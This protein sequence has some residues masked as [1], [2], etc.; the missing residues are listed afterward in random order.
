METKETPHAKHRERMINKFLLNP[1]S[2]AEHELL[3][4]LLYAVIKRQDTNAL[5]HRILSYFNN[6]K[7]V[8]DADIETLQKIKGVG[9][10]VATHIKTIGL[11]MYKAY[12]DNKSTTIKTLKSFETFKQVVKDYFKDTSTEKFMVFYLDDKNK[13]ISVN[14]HTSKNSEYVTIDTSLLLDQL[15]I[16]KPKQVVIAHNHPSGSVS[17]SNA[18][19]YTTSKLVML[20]KLHDVSLLDH[21]IIGKDKYYSYF[22]EGRLQN[23]QKITDI[24]KIL[25][26]SISEDN[27]ES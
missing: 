16:L 19:D 12:M 15:A 10:R 8:F 21:I 11:I 7:A 24:D 1:D 22:A 17:P 18:D 26:K 2:F 6:L 13:I 3:E 20:L 9:I 25:K 27:Y 4:I 23:I 14:E 5:A